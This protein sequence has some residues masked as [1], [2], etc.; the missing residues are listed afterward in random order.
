MMPPRRPAPGRPNLGSGKTGSR[1]PQSE[2]F[3]SR[4]QYFVYVAPESGGG[5]RVLIVDKLCRFGGHKETYEVYA[6]EVSRGMIVDRIIK[7]AEILD[8][9]YL[10]SISGF[11][12]N[13][14]HT[15][16]GNIREFIR[17]YG[18]PPRKMTVWMKIK[19]ALGFPIR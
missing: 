18:S 2:P 15:Y 7:Q 6:Y 17:T 11:G 5:K 14:F 8:Y 13:A 1:A 9:V 4:H 10:G 3:N 16:G 12:A 19:R